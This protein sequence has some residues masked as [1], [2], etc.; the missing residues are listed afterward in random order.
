MKKKLTL[1][2][3]LWPLFLAAQDATYKNG[4][5][6]I[7]FHKKKDKPQDTVQQPQ[8]SPYSSDDDDDSVKTKRSRVVRPPKEVQPKGEKPDYAKNGLFQLLFHAGINATQVDDDGDVDPGFTNPGAEFGIGTMIKVH[9]LLSV[10]L[11]LNYTMKGEREIFTFD[12]TTIAN[13]R[14]QFRIA[15]DYIEIPLGLNIYALPYHGQKLMFFN[16][17]LTPAINVRFKEVNADGEDITAFAQQP[18]RFELSTFAGLYFQPLQNFAV[19]AK[20]QYGFT[21]VRAINNYV[22]TGRLPGEHNILLNL[23]FMY[24]MNT[25][26]KKK[27]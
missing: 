13:S 15:W 26:K 5:I 3:F 8:Q 27:K 14:Q 2:I 18:N 19:G 4:T 10:S 9:R 21:K 7:D 6:T 25:V 11:Q 24:I 22:A 17:G 20:F 16:I 1:W 23:D 12:S